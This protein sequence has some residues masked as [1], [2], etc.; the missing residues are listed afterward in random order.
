[1]QI[2]LGSARAAL[3]LAADSIAEALGADKVDTFLYD[4]TR[5]SLVA[6]GSSNQPLS[7]L[8][9]Q[10]GLN[11]LQVSNGGRVVHV[12]KTGETFR[13]GRLDLDTSELLGVKQGLG[14]RSKVG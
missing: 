6:V 11:V 7:S 9:H 12:F 14:I 13:S 10:L 5:D 8:Q 1:M 4:P 2:P 3:S